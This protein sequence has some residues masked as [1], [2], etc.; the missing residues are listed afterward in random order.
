MWQSLWKWNTCCT[1]NSRRSLNLGIPASKKCYDP[2]RRF[3]RHSAP[4]L[5]LLKLLRSQGL[6]TAQ[7]YIHELHIF[8]SKRRIGLS[9]KI[10]FG[11]VLHGELS[12][13]C[14]PSHSRDVLWPNT[15]LFSPFCAITFYT[16]ICS[17]QLTFFGFVFFLSLGQQPL[18]P[19]TTL[20]SLDLDTV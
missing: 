1:V 16:F 6:S 8:F 7:K 15:T 5:Y 13:L 19:K 3:F 10:V 17:S 2:I 9:I 20:P 12:T 14:E 18:A 4:L 11:S